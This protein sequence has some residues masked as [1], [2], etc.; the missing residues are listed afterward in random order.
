M[1]SLTGIRHNLLPYWLTQYPDHELVGAPIDEA[2]KPP[3][4][5]S[6][7]AVTQWPARRSV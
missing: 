2:A 6:A 3:R 7:N 4:R 5:C 1:A